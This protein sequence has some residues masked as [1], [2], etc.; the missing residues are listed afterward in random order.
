[1]AIKWLICLFISQYEI[2]TLIFGSVGTRSWFLG[3]RVR[4]FVF[5]DR[6]KLERIY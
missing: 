4:E 5:V 2:L 3:S 1:M 6:V